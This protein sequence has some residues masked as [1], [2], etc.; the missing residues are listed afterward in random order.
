[1]AQRRIGQAR[2]RFGHQ[3]EPPRSSLDELDGLIDWAP[4]A[5]ALG[6]IY[7]AAKGEPAW[8]PL[9]LFKALLIAVWYDVSDVK[10]AEAI[11]DRGSFRRFCGFSGE[12]PTPERTAFVRFRRELVGRGLDRVLFEKVAAALR[13]RSVTV[14]SGTIVDATVIRSASEADGDARW[15]GH[16][17]RKAI[18]GYKAHVGADVDTALV[19]ELVVTPGNVHDG[20]AG[21]GAL[22]DDP[23]DVYAD[24]A[25]RGEIFGSAV[26]ARGG[27]PR[28]VLTGMW[29]KPGDDTLRK[30]RRWNY[31]VQRVRCR[32]EKIFG[33]WKRSYGLHR[34]RW[35]GQAKASLQ[36][37]LTA[38]AYNL[39][40]ALRLV[41]PQAA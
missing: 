1:M 30:L 35:L 5:Q 19:E 34:M 7:A 25:Y 13:A 8:P 29:G 39:K 16:R 33:V 26:Q 4:L 20:R 28:L 40:R 36:V 3:A 2:L 27:T 41:A 17:V 18:H 14:K 32:I 23:G 21:G 9:A 38:I 6:G 10:L 15:S 22:P 24:S 37:R 11:E 12:E 31:D